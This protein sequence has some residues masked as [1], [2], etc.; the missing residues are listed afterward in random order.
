[1]TIIKMTETGGVFRFADNREG[2]AFLNGLR[3]SVQAKQSQQNQKEARIHRRQNTLSW[4]APMAYIR[5]RII[6]ET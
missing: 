4:P 2:Y 1:M 6:S 3:L 5:S